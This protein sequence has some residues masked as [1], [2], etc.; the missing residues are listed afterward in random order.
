MT[1][2]EGVVSRRRPNLADEVAAHL[3]DAILSGR[4]R[5]GARIDQDAIAEEDRKSTRLN[6]SH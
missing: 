3:R 6:S 2:E 4:L 1:A 5:S